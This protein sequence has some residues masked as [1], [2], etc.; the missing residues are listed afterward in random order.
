M[1]LIR[2]YRLVA[3]C[4]LH[5]RPVPVLERP[6]ESRFRAVRM[7][8]EEIPR[9]HLRNPL[10]VFPCQDRFLT[11]VGN[12]RLA[13]LLALGWTEAPCR[14]APRWR[15]GEHEVLKFHPY[16]ELVGVGQL[17]YRWGPGSPDDRNGQRTMYSY[18]RI[19]EHIRT[20]T[21]PT[22]R[23]V[24]PFYDTILPVL[25]SVCAGGMR[26]YLAVYRDPKTGKQ[27]TMVGNQRLCISR[28]LEWPRVAC[29]VTE[30]WDEH[31]VL[32][33]FPYV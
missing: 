24:I 18:G 14:I 31:A 15:G 8:V 17:E 20:G 29:R 19:I 25:R 16:E 3:D 27:Y 12:Q 7:L 33:A 11:L 9:T 2:V 32:R 1:A 6:F 21:V 13:A 10:I 4:I 30:S 28:A 5:N 26:N 22:E 23:T